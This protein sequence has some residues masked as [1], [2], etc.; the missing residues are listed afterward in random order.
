[1]VNGL[2]MCSAS[3]VLGGQGNRQDSEA[4]GFLACFLKNYLR[5]EKKSTHIL[6]AYL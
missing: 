2:E 3:S 5:K 6:L 4:R 1:M